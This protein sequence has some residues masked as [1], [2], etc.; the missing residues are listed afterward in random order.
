MKDSVNNDI[1]INQN[2]NS[3]EL[4]N[5]SL[6]SG[7]DE[8]VPNDISVLNSSNSV[9]LNNSQ[10]IN[11]GNSQDNEEAENTATEQKKETKDETAEA[12]STDETAETITELSDDE[13]AEIIADSVVAAESKKKGENQKTKGKKTKEPQFDEF[14]RE[15]LE[16][17]FENMLTMSKNTIKL[18]YSKL[19][20]EIYLYKYIKNKF[21]GDGEIFYKGDNTLFCIKLK[22]EQILLYCA[23]PEGS[24]DKNVYPHRI[25][26]NEE[27]KDVPIQIT[28]NS[29]NAALKRAL[30]LVNLVMDINAVMKAK[31]VV[32]VAYAEKYPFNPNAVLR[33]NENIPPNEEEYSGEEYEDIQGEITNYLTEKVAEKAPT[34]S[35]KKGREKL[36]EQRQTAKSLKAAIAL[37]EPIVYF[38]D[39]AA[40]KENNA[41]FVNIQQVLNDRFLGKLVPQHFF[42]IAEGSE[43]IEKLN[44]LALEAAVLDCNVKPDKYFALDISSRLLIKKDNVKKLIKE[45]KTENENLIMA[46]DCS[47]LE[48]LG[49]TAK[50]AITSLKDAGI[51][52][53]LDNIEQAG[54]RAL[55]EFFIDYLRLDARYYTEDQPKSIA[56]LDMLTG[57]T[58]VQ[59]I[60]TVANQVENTKQALFMLNHGVDAIQGRAVSVPRRLVH[61]ALKE[62]KPLPVSGG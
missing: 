61:I 37:T 42:A 58:K 41:L 27:Y 28:I 7:M 36:E 13:T 22:E 6:D 50:N 14:G 18:H 56:Q 9:P 24:L 19:K 1:I 49:E 59:G 38:Y 25:I 40:D 33:G 53:M 2:N 8:A 20:N 60:T 3:Q 29:T 26:K 55:T 10:N 57:F 54:L 5:V 43:R 4:D 11:E 21:K 30:E 17:T 45:A 48:A 35:A 12:E 34:K 52:I 39:I 44:F 23:L 62:Q 15:I 32:P 16:P 46:F 51:K 31:S 47:L